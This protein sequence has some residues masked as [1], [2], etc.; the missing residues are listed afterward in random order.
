MVVS[1]TRYIHFAL[2]QVNSLTRDTNHIV[3]YYVGKLTFVRIIFWAKR[4]QKLFCAR[5][6]PASL[7][8]CQQD[9]EYYKKA[10]SVVSLTTD[11]KN[12]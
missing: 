5:L 3:V 11:R 12:P 8:G 6:F 9:Q 1:P 2:M 7:E 4:P 10:N